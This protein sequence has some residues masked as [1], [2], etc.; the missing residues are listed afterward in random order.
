MTLKLEILFFSTSL[1]K[2][3][4]SNGK[5]ILKTFTIIHLFIHILLKE[6]NMASETFLHIGR[7]QLHDFDKNSVLKVSRIWI[8]KILSSYEFKLNVSIL[9]LDLSKE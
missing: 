2:K 7:S 9:F 3:L 4:A 5:G 8:F 6:Q 1:W